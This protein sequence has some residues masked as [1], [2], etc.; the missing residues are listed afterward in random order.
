M[1]LRNILLSHIPIQEESSQ[2]VCENQNTKIKKKYI[3]NESISKLV[4]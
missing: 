1:E 4:F 2:E 3:Q